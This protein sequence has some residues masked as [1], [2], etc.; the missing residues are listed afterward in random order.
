MSRPLPNIMTLPLVLLAVDSW[1]KREKKRFIAYAG[2]SI[3]IFRAE[4]VIF[5]GLLLI[6]D[7]FYKRITLT[8]LL[9]IGV[10]TGIIILAS[11]III[12]SIFWGRLIWPEAEVLWFNTVLNK[13]VEYGTSPFFWY[14]YSAL[15]RALGLSLLFVPYGLYVE[16]RIRV[17]T[18]PAIL[19]VLLYSFLP[20]KELRFIIYVFPMLNLASACGCQRLWMNR[21]K[22]Y[23]QGA[24][25][26]IAISHLIGNFI[27]TVFLLTVS[28]T[29]YPGGVA[30]SRLHRIAA[31]EPSITIHIDNLSAQTG[32][33]RFTEINS[34]WTYRKDE[35]LKA[36]D[37]ELHAFDYLL[38]EVKN[39]Y[40][41]EMRLL[42]QTHE[43][44]ELVECFS[45]IGLHYASIFPIRIRTKPC[46]MIMRKKPNGVLLK[47]FFDAEEQEE[48]E[49]ENEDDDENSK[50][51]EIL[52]T[53]Q[54]QDINEETN[55]D[56]DDEISVI[57]V[58]PKIF[59]KKKRLRSSV[60]KKKIKEIIEAGKLEAENIDLNDKN[61]EAE[62]KSDVEE[63]SMEELNEGQ[64][65][66]DYESKI[67]EELNSKIN[68]KKIISQKKTKQLIDELMKIDLSALCDLTQM[69]QQ[70]CL[71]KI[72]DGNVE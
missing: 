48:E 32:I 45:N 15:P 51:D 26:L 14:F 49:E 4:L 61:E 72:L 1:L 57:K 31:N 40:S 39:K 46:I 19:F 3:I 28:K 59:K 63:E 2:A 36:G 24:L 12:D 65:D 9:K 47:R 23:W 44:V 69:S 58:E 41:P 29:N 56:N 5:L 27:L 33:T 37:E 64:N 67:D 43:K 6:Y 7:I 20:H 50:A 62:N 8:E 10:P 55:S 71:K 35:H 53:N 42:A 22:S 13:S 18:I 70:E 66:D 17:I 30:I 52:E 34:N 25:S 38:V 11:T 21:S 54:D 68:I 16:S 60:L